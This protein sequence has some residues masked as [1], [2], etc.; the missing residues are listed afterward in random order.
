MVIVLS[1]ICGVLLVALII[2]TL[3][4][5]RECKYLQIAE[6]A[7]IS[8]VEKSK[9][10]EHIPTQDTISFPSKDGF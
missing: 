7:L 8:L 1:C 4:Y 5:I 2:M 9:E 6:E 10:P 3:L